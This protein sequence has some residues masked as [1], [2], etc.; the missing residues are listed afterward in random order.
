MNEA[1]HGSVQTTGHEYD[2]IAEYDNPVPGWWHVLWFLSFVFL[3]LYL[4][5]SLMS[6]FYPSPI[7]RLEAAQA[8][9]FERLFAEIGVLAND[10]ATV[11]S[12]MNDADWMSF[13]ASTFRGNC[14]SCHAGDGGGLI[15]PN[16]TDDMFKSVNVITDLHGV[17]ANGAAAGAMPAWGTRL[18]QNE[19]VLLSAYVASLRGTT[20]AAPR[21]PEGSAIAPWPVAADDAS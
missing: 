14:A 4:P 15:G 16:L 17:I 2:G 5:I 1:D 8:A 9:E 20:P 12:L 21:P 10:E 3:V 18:H 11:V 13:A 7:R 6:P 19:I